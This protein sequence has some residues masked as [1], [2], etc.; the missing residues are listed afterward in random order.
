MRGSELFG[1]QNGYGKQTV[2]WINEYA[3][4]NKLKLEARL[5]GQV[6]HTQYFGDF[7][8]FSWMGN[9]KVARRITTLV[10]KR[11]HTKI[12]EGGYKT[13][14]NILSTRKI[15]YALVKEGIRII[16]KLKFESLRFGKGEWS[17]IDEETN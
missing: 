1:V 3:T 9:V 8:M 10:S 2:E 17:I 14:E 6:I 15:D 7:E 5:Y 13:R 11:F 16:G 12:I 4:K